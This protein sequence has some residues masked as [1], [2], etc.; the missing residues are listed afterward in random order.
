MKW[1]TAAGWGAGHLRVTGIC[2]NGV[3][4]MMQACLTACVLR[5][6]FSCLQD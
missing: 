5:V 6:V 3:D 1:F 4:A 2:A